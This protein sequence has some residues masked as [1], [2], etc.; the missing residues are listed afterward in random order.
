MAKLTLPTV[1]N[2]LGLHGSA[3]RVTLHRLRQFVHVVPHMA[4][5]EKVF[6]TV[7]HQAT[8]LADFRPG[9]FR[10]PEPLIWEFEDIFRVRYAA[11][12]AGLEPLLREL[13]ERAG[14]PVVLK[15]RRPEPLPPPDLERL[16][17]FAPWD[18]SVLE[19]VCHHERGLIRF[20]RG[21]KVCPARLIAQ[22]A[23]AWPKLH[24]VVTSTRLADA[25]TYQGTGA[26]RGQS[27]S[28]HQPPPQ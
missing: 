5:L 28:L 9:V 4:G 25:R 26:L 3:C 14:V 1:R 6:Y 18:T 20:D 10:L 13:F 17:G 27:D 16:D 11:G 2:I 22:I 8:D 7:N 19:F 23:R 12:F 24:I 15:G 21:G